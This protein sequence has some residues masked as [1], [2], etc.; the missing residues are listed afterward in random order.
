MWAA[1][2]KVDAAMGDESTSPPDPDPPTTPGHVHDHRNLVNVT[3]NQHHNQVHLLHGTDHSDVDS[4]GTPQIR[5]LLAF[6]DSNK[7]DLQRRLNFVRPYVF[8][9]AYEAE[10]AVYDD[11][12]TMVA[13]KQTT[14]RAAP[15]PSGT[16]FN[17]YDGTS[18]TAPVTVK[19]IIFGNRYTFGIGGYVNGY[20]IYVTAGN[21]YSVY[22]V[23]DP[24]GTADANSLA[25][26]TASST[27]WA[28]FGSLPTVVPVGTV[29]DLVVV[30]QEPDPTPTTFVGDWSYTTPNNTGAPGAG[31][32]IH[33][34]LATDQLRINKTDSNAVDRSVD[35]ATL[36]V[37]DVIDWGGGGTRWAVQS[38][39]DN[40]TWINFGVSPS[41]QESPD[42][43]H[44]FTFETVTATPITRMEDV[45]WWGLNPPVNGTVQG[46][47]I[48]DGAYGDI[49]PNTSAYGSDLL[50]QNADISDD[51]DLL[52]VGSGVGSGTSSGEV[53]ATNAD[54]GWKD[55]FANL[56]AAASGAGTPSLQPFG[57][58]G[59]AKQRRFGIGDSVYVVWHINHDIKP[60]STA[61]MHMHWSTDG[62][63]LDPVAWEFNY[64]VGTRDTTTSTDYFPADTTIT[65][66][67]SSD[68]T[69]WRHKVSEDAVGFTIPPVDSIIV[70]EIKRVAP[71]AGTNSDGV[72][73]IF[74]DIHY[75]SDRDATPSRAPDFY[76]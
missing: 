57:P 19:Q 68:G 16:A 42:G 8:G 53:G 5:D 55:N 43:V 39:T 71:S 72:F 59:N 17:I 63:D 56:T 9:D 37:G 73:G 41:V 64:T 24:L 6:N 50:V 26:F 27:G 69:A 62:S 60:E 10:D 58:S 40:G 13:N 28:D 34:N 7:F 52:A 61:Y 2:G 70:C 23:I 44:S 33:A 54:E 51:W 49:V 25:L 32:I 30:V 76:S 65:I 29:L 20:R 1:F 75:Q 45:N 31:V 47:Y 21:T 14:D 38:I 67:D 35:L 48:E 12:W 66:E 74:A 46:L 15:Q 4:T 36:T 18:P 3:A 22:R 11:G